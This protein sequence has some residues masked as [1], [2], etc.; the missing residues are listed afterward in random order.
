[1][2]PLWDG[3]FL[4]R[5]P[6]WSVCHCGTCLFV[7]GS[8]GERS[9]LLSVCLCWNGPSYDNKMCSDVMIPL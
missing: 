4:E 8:F 2:V 6:L 5:T 1:M 3:S 9:S 7:D